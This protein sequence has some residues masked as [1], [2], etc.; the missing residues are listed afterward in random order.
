MESTPAESKHGDTI[1]PV[2][3]DLTS[4]ALLSTPT[5][6]GDKVSV[7][8]DTINL[9]DLEVRIK[10]G[11]KNDQ[12]FFNKISEHDTKLTKMD[13]NI[14]ASTKACEEKFTEIKQEIHRLLKTIDSM[15][16]MLSEQAKHYDDD[17]DNM[18]ENSKWYEEFKVFQDTKSTQNASVKKN[19]IKL[20]I[21]TIQSN[22]Y[23]NEIEKS[24]KEESEKIVHEENENSVSI[25]FSV[26][27]VKDEVM[28]KGQELKSMEGNVT[29]LSDSVSEEESLAYDNRANIES[30]NNHQPSELYDNEQCY[31]CNENKVQGLG[32]DNNQEGCYEEESRK[33]EE[34]HGTKKGGCPE[35]DSGVG[36]T[37]I[38]TDNKHGISLLKRQDQR[39]LNNNRSKLHKQE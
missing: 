12:A 35:I 13:K 37:S 22:K 39:S 21:D 15:S 5:Q 31:D 34:C 23:I 25:T 2:T 1:S 20:S 18:N 28:F 24:V 4:E 3:L 9:D 17:I 33:D 32:T 27:V 6:E 16:D 30:Y 29:F 14:K 10:N 36:P 11:E 19:L 38:P 26:D 8:S 7:G